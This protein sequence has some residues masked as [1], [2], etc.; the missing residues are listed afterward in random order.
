MKLRIQTRRFPPLDAAICSSSSELP[1]NTEY[2]NENAT[3]SN[4]NARSRRHD[5]RI[6]RRG[7]GIHAPTRYEQRNLRRPAK[8]LPPLERARGTEP[9]TTP[10]GQTSRMGCWKPQSIPWM[11]ANVEARQ[12]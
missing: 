11:N 9:A 3:P 8:N 1:T 10:E 6:T 7:D 2:T 12:K 5:G 4:R